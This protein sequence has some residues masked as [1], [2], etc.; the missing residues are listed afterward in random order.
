VIWLLLLAGAGVW[1]WKR[2][3][4]PAWQPADLVAILMALIAF[5][6]LGQG[7][8][9]LPLLALAGTA[10][11]FWFARREGMPAEE[12]R[13]LLEVP[14]DADRA[15]IQAAH[16]KLI[17]RVHPDAGGSAELARKV[18]AARDT[19]LSELRRKG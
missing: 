5:R 1:A 2:G 11:W 10:Y 14:A 8:I 3:Q 12:A 18:N 15:A 16:R 17:A 19:L 9:L 13:R 6:M 7:R 4:L